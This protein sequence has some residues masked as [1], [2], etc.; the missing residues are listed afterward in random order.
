MDRQGDAIGRARGSSA[1]AALPSPA[2]DEA[3]SLPIAAYGMLSNCTSAALV[4]S[5]GSI[6]WLCLPRFDSPALFSRLLDPD[7]GHWAITPVD[8]YTVERRYLPGTLVLETT[9]M[10]ATGAVRLIDALAF[11]EGLRGHDIGLGAP[12]ELLRLVEGASGIVELAMELA[13]RPEYGLV[14]PLFRQLEDGGRTFGGASPVAVRAGVPVNVEGTTMRAAFRVA[15]GE[16]AGFALRW[17][18]PEAVIPAPIAPDDVRGRIE[19]AA[20]SWRSWEKE[21]DIYAGRHRELVRLSARVLQGMTYRPTGAIVA[22]VTTS[23]PEDVGGA[24]NWDYRYSWIRDASL[25]M[26]A[27]YIGA[28]PDEVG[29]FAS[30]MT[31]SAGGGD[32]IDRS[33]Q[34][35][36]GIGGEHDLSERELPHLRGWRNSRPVRVGNGAWN[37]RQL[38]VYGEFLDVTYLYRE[39]LGELHPEIQHFAAQLADA[40]ARNWSHKDA[41]MWEMRG[42]PRHHLS[43]KVLCWTALDRAVKLAPQLGDY[44]KLA[45]WTTERDRIHATVLKRG[46]SEARQAYAQSY[47]VDELDAAVLVMPLVGFLPA[48]DPRMRSTIDAIERDLTEDGLVLRYR[49]R[50]E[51]VNADGLTGEEGTFVICSFWLVSCLARAGE[52]ERAERLFDRLVGYANDLGLLAEEIDTKNNELLGNFPQAFSHI[53]LITAARDIDCARG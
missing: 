35:M 21:H 1:T 15:K 12:P 34:I 14:H 9:F 26:Q 38:D 13:P 28:C 44:A 8:E 17:V 23:L 5:D 32:G 10:T 24:R 52:P 39:R 46:W 22:A 45:E 4:G 29:E 37:Q 11:A 6:D 50:A 20:E 7:A 36:Y 48:T 51:G 31:S 43:S 41:G 40:A 33:L 19:D 30:F 2:R 18:P 3:G 42:E 25:T 47:D 16:R 53:G 27:L 49:N